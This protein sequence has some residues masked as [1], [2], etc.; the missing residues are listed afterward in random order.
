MADHDPGAAAAGITVTGLHVAYGPVTALRAVDAHFPA[1]RSTAVMGPNGA[2]KSTLVKAL[3]DL[4]PRTAGQVRFDGR[5]IDAVRRQIAYVPQHS[6]V[7]RDFP[8]DAAGTVLLGTYPRL[9]WLRRPGRAERAQA[10]EALAQVGMSALADRQIGRLSGGQLQRVFLARALVQR[11]RYLLLDEPF[12]GVDAT[13]EQII[14]DLLRA[15]RDDGATVVVVHHDFR[16]V[17]E[18]FD[19]VLL[20][21]GEVVAAGTVAEALTDQALDRAYRPPGT[22]R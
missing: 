10:A 17:A 20:L 11:P 21:D 9:G 7:D 4:V 15:L 16:T 12:V 8:I 2:G 19:R 3:V 5:A 14:V 13:S 22:D 18:Y 6:G 1:S